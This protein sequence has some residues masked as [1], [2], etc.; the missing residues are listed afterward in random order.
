MKNNPGKCKLK[1]LNLAS[2]K[3][4]D[5]SLFNLCEALIFWNPPLK[6]IDFSHN[7][8]EKNSAISLGD[9]AI[10]AH[11]LRILKLQWNKIHSEG[12]IHLCENLAHSATIRNLDLSWNML[13]TKG[14]KKTQEFI[15]ALGKVVNSGML[16][17]LDISYNSIKLEECK[18]FG[19][20]IR[21]NETLYGL[22]MHGNQWMVDTYGV[23]RT[24]KKYNPES[25]GKDNFI[26]YHSNDGKNCS[27]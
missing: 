12:A 3:L 14:T 11:D 23:V 19:D 8:M 5:Q 20:L 4:S 25:Y 13:G 18:L 10:N 22:H 24:E 17:H 26:G 2:N 16:R 7:K 27:D 21:N 15:H 6:E 9:F 1:F